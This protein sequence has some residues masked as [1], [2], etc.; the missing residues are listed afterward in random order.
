[1]RLPLPL[2]PPL[3]RVG[4]WELGEDGRV[5]QR[6]ARLSA[7]GVMVEVAGSEFC[8]ARFPMTDGSRGGRWRSDGGGGLAGDGGEAARERR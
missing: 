6:P 1:L 2:E 7:V 4:L 3:A 5:E 8:V